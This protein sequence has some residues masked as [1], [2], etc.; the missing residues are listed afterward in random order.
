MSATT[1]VSI[2]RKLNAAFL[3]SKK[4]VSSRQHATNHR[5]RATNQRRK[6]ELPTDNLWVFIIETLHITM[7]RSNHRRVGRFIFSL[8][9]IPLCTLL[10]TAEAV[11]VNSQGIGE[12]L[13]YPYYTVRN[14]QVTLLTVVNTEVHGKAL[15]VLVR[16]GKNGAP[17]L[18]FNLFM[19][20]FDVWT[21]AI[22]ATAEGGAQLITS[23]VS[24]TNPRIPPSGARFRNSAYATDAPA[25]QGL[26]R[27]REGF[28]EVIEMASI[29]IES[30]TTNDILFSNDGDPP[31]CALLSNT[32]I[33]QRL[34]DYSNPTGGISGTGTIVSA[35]MSTG[36]AATA[37]EGLEL[38]LKLTDSGDVVGTT[39]ATGLNKTARL[40]TQ[41]TETSSTQT[42]AA[43]FANSID[44]VSAVLMVEN[45]YGEYAQD[46]TF[47]TDWVIT[48]PT[49]SFYTNPSSSP[50][51]RSPF[52]TSWDRNKGEACEPIF[53]EA[54]DRNSFYYP[55]TD[56][57][58]GIFD[59]PKK[60][61]WVSTVVSFRQ[62]SS[63]S[64]PRFLRSVNT[65][66][67]E[68]A[69][70]PGRLQSPSV[71]GY[72]RLGFDRASVFRAVTDPDVY[73]ESLPSSRIT[74]GK[75]NTVDQTLTGPIRFYGWPVIGVSVVGA[76]FD[77]T[78]GNF[79]NSFPLS[80][81]P[82]IVPVTTT[83]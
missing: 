31:Q 16:E 32:T 56:D 27:T 4:P 6:L 75:S 67:L 83:Q 23:D 60:M 72:A 42:I 53:Y 59:T 69:F 15:K 64:A 44:A 78:A 68:F 80:G 62:F 37:L 41:N 74:V 25:L 54:F 26:D 76:L 7:N 52:V 63:T 61:C 40:I 29:K 28:I 10:N 18:S 14:D 57:N 22:I 9:A 55:R 77:N 33:Q 82:R 24:C 35:S 5:K 20:P 38:P 46:A 50:S 12:A 79:N 45:L 43:D 47:A 58:F 39:L 2:H 70:T 36:Y 13:I 11:S 81:R 34:A 66:T 1:T 73:L 21:A 30:A 49:R 48:S 19:S 65:E 51:A 17:V 3:Y 8:L 71:S